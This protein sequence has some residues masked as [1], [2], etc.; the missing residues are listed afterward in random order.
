MSFGEFMEMML[1]LRGGQQA[2]VK[3]IMCL[4]KGVNKKIMKLLDKM[5]R[6]ATSICG[7][8]GAPTGNSMNEQQEIGD[9]FG[10]FFSPSQADATQ[11]D[12]QEVK[13]TV[14]DGYCCKNSTR[15]FTHVCR[16]AGPCGA[17]GEMIRNVRAAHYECECCGTLPYCE[18]CDGGTDPDLV[19]IM[20]LRRMSAIDCRK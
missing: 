12:E 20:Y 14:S 3:D 9:L 13:V 8:H 17:C 19:R 5:D 6:I 11:Q 7:I 15:T 18:K 10:D 16:V 1:D 4:R 2:T